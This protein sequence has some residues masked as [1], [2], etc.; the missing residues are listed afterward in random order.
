MKRI[1]FWCLIYVPLVLLLE[2]TAYVLLDRA[3][4]TRIKSRVAG[5]HVS[6][7]ADTL[8]HAVSREPRFRKASAP[9]ERSIV[10]PQKA[11]RMYHPEL[12]WD[13]PPY[14]IYTDHNGIAHKHGP[15]GERL[16]CTSFPTSDIATYGDSFTHCEE[17]ADEHTW[18]TLLAAKA[19]TNVLNFGT[20]GYG[21]DQA[22]LKYYRHDRVTSRLVLLGI[23]PEN[24]N[25]IVNVYPPFYIYESPLRLTKPRFTLRGDEI[26]LSPN[27]IGTSADLWKLTEESFLQRIGQHDYWYQLDRRLPGLDFPFLSSII[28]WRK[29]VG[30]WLRS[31]VPCPESQ[32]CDNTGPFNLWKEDEPFRLMCHI[33]DLFE[34]IAR[35]RGQIP[36]IVI[37]PHKDYVREQRNRRVYSAARFLQYLD[38]KG[39]TYID[40][41][42]AMARSDVTDRELDKLYESHARPEGNAL[43]ASLLYDSLRAKSLLSIPSR[44]IAAHESR[45][46]AVHAGP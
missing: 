31:L 3:I 16:T 5:D 26:V 43:T 10:D 30:D 29:P 38:E 34:T 28:E 20:G 45:S 32:V 23:L 33:V 6:H 11:P 36:V 7:R 25:R 46:G 14:S 8:P 17:V 2:V 4:P 42:D 27:P 18:Q 21:T 37:M 44:S 12:G 39:Y 19:R 22:V 41:I 1:I 35:S 13:Y 15:G 9:H 24:I 40:L